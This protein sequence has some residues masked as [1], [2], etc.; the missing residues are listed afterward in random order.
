MDIA[1]EIEDLD[2]DGRE[3]RKERGGRRLQCPIPSM[4]AD[5]F[6]GGQVWVTI[7]GFYGLE[8]GRLQLEKGTFNI[9]SVF[10]EVLNLIKPIASVKKL[11][12]TLNIASDLSVYA[13]GDEKRLMQTIMFLNWISIVQI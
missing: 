4:V 9:H 10:R 6:S 13:V 8:D 1:V 11:T 5:G 3:E 12:V 2:G 7:G